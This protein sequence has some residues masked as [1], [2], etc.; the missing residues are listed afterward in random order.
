MPTEVSLPLNAEASSSND[1]ETSRPTEVHA[2]R[3]EASLSHEQPEAAA[4]HIEP[5]VSAEEEEQA[6]A[7]QERE[8]P[9]C[10]DDERTVD[11]EAAPAWQIF[12]EDPNLLYIA[13]NDHELEKSRHSANKQHK[14]DE[15][16]VEITLYTPAVHVPAQAAIVEVPKLSPLEVY[17]QV[18]DSVVRLQKFTR[19]YLVRAAAAVL[20][21]LFMRS[22][23]SLTILYLCWADPTTV[24][25]YAGRARDEELSQLLLWNLCT[26]SFYELV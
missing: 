7:Q 22:L 16:H 15:P 14:H 13:T 19:G 18:L 3:S 8:S 2:S 10:D 24:L 20:T 6:P 5:L 26:H 9:R 21:V 23:L 12:P 11:E 1:A 4:E 25:P 17:Q